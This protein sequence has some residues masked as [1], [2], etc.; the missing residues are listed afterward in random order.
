MHKV[1]DL[2]WEE[3]HILAAGGG[4]GQGCSVW[5]A[6][7]HFPITGGLS[8][9]HSAT[10]FSLGG[11]PSIPGTGQHPGCTLESRGTTPS[12]HWAAFSPRPFSLRP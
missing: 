2:P 8:A 4:Q 9:D 5:P 6:P 12:E 11:V 7:C 10:L 1:L 3:P